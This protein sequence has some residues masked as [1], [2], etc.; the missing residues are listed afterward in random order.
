MDSQLLAIMMHR[1]GAMLDIT[2]AVTLFSAAKVLTTEDFDTI[3]A[4]CEKQFMD[5]KG[6]NPEIYYAE[7]NRF[8]HLFGILRNH[9]P[10]NGEQP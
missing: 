4:F 9:F 6:S 2:T 10:E 5:T 8:K 1:I 3:M 7:L